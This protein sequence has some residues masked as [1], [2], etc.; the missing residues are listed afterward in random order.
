MELAA[1]R[2]ARRTWNRVDANNIQASWKSISRDFLTLF[3]TIQTKSAETAIDASGMMLAEQGVYITPHALANPNAFAGWAPSGLDIASYFQSPVFAALH[4]IRTGSSPLEALEY[5]RNLLV[6]LTSLAV[7]DTARQ[8]E[9]LDITS[10]PKV[11]YVRVESAS[12]CDRCM[13]LAGKW[14]RFNEGFLRHPHCHGR[15]VPCNQGMAKQQGWISD[16]MEGFKS[17]SREEQDKRFGANYAQAIRDGAD[18]YQVVNSKRGMQRVGKGYTALTTS[19]GTTRYGWASM[20]YAQQS[21]RRMKRRLSIDGIYS[22]TGGDREKTISALKA[23]GYYVDND[24]RGKVP[25]I[26]KSMWLHD[27]TYRQG[28]VELL[29]AA[30]KRVQTAKLRY[31]A[32]L[33]GPRNRGPVRTRIPPMGHLRRTD[34]PAMIQRIERKN[35]DPANQNQQ[36]G[37]NESKK[38]EN[39]GG[40]DWQSKF[41]GQRKVN[42]DLEKKLNEAYAKADKVDEL[43]KQIA[44]LQGKEAEYEAARKEQAVKDE[45]LAAANQ[46][47]LKAEVRAAASGKLADP[48]DALRYLDLSKFTVTDDGSVDSQAIANSIGELLEQKPYLG[49]AEQAPSGA[50][51]TPP[52]GTRDGDRHQGQLTRDD[53][54]T[55]SPAEIVKAQQDGRLKDLLGAN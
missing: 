45:A 23:N 54:K 32:V 24:W 33:E 49:K 6:M 20:Q 50:N 15:H 35:M 8:A 44:A 40:E 43:E 47:I 19:E 3:S 39:T 12:C 46:R 13:L 48:A 4:A 42:R 51:I 27:N 7:M 55:M 25:E 37:D 38:P 18:I 2:A 10:R 9:S 36:T 26:R 28:R 5:G 30:E 16:P 14:F 41:E 21:G 52:S 34:F 29:T 53:L 31:E 17:L 11:G 22:L 1:D